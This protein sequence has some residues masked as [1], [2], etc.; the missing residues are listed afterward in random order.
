M[1]CSFGYGLVPARTSAVT[2]APY[3]RTPAWILYYTFVHTQ[4]GPRKAAEMLGLAKAKWLLMGSGVV[5]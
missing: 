2:T 4:R 5:V 1:R 3:P